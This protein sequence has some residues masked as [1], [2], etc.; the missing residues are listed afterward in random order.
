MVTATGKEAILDVYPVDWFR[1]KILANMGVLDEY[2]A[3]FD[4]CDVLNNKLAINFV[5]EDPT[6]MQF[7]DSE[8]YAHNIA[9]LELLHSDLPC[10]V[11]NLS[12]QMDQE[13]IGRWCQYHHLSVEEV[14]K[15]FVK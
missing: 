14:T 10:G 12:K 5:L 1:G 4:A 6:P 2:G 7:M 9:A 13:I 8:F 11:S 15:W 3:Q